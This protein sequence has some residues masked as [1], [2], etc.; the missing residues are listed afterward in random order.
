MTSKTMM[1]RAHLAAWRSSGQSAAAFCRS[2]GLAYAQFVYWQR[3]LSDETSAWVPVRVDGPA[4]T[5]T[6]ML[7]LEWG[8]RNGVSLRVTGLGVADVV[9]LVRGL[10]C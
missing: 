7:A 1:W 3:K 8:L 6:S 2:Q 4:A 10:S 9:A 5:T